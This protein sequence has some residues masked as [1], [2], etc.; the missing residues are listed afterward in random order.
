MDGW[1]QI[2]YNLSNGLFPLV[3]ILFCVILIFLGSFFLINLMLAVIMEN[4]IISESNINNIENEKLEQ[5]K[6]DL[7]MRVKKT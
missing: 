2:F 4:Y 1:S 5:E 3:P 7:E 6:E